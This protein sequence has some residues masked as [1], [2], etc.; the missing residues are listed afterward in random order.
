MILHPDIA[1]WLVEAQHERLAEIA[2]RSHP[3]PVAARRRPRKPD[4]EGA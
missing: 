4:A 3:R 2:R 1:R